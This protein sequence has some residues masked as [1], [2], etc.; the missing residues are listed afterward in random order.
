MTHAE[1]SGRLYPLGAPFDLERNLGRAYNRSMELLPEDGWGYFLDHDAMAATEDW[2]AQILDAMV[3]KPD[4]GLFTAVTNRIG[5]AWQRAQ[6][7]DRNNHQMAYHFEMG[8]RRLE[9]RTLLDITD[10]K[11][12]GGVT[13][14]LSKVAWRAAGGFVDGLLCVDHGMHFALRKAGYR[15]YLIESWYVY[16]RRR[17]FGANLHKDSPRA[18][19][20]PCTGL[21]APPTV[22]IPLVST[23]AAA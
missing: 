4:A 17:A 8:K 20:C 9:K 5:A 1:A 2:H 14:V 10:T 19:N 15:I 23:N 11:G 3:T 7:T 13:L 6:E 16:H 12:F 22:R 18:A 21:E